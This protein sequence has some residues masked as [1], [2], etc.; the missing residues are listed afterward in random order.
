MTCW[1]RVGHGALETGRGRRGGEKEDVALLVRCGYSTMD[2]WARDEWDTYNKQ[3]AKKR[4][5]KSKRK[6]SNKDE[7]EDGED[8]KMGEDNRMFGADGPRLIYGRM[9]DA[10]G[11][12]PCDCNSVSGRHFSSM[13]KSLPF[14]MA[15]PSRH[16]DVA[17]SGTSVFLR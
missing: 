6:R 5:S 1:G 2:R 14:R 16:W 17:V 7:G 3:K 10:K 9:S 4:K 12:H 11:L 15:S 13:C 8:A